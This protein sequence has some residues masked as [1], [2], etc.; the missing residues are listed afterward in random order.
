MKETRKCVVCGKKYT[1]IRGN[2]K[3]CGSE[4]EKIATLKQVE[5]RNKKLKVERR[6]KKKKK[7]QD[8]IDIA[9]AAREAGMSYGQYVAK[10]GL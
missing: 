7:N 8:I 3:Y 4:C 10:M 2:Q 5:V 6:R 9:I 1:A